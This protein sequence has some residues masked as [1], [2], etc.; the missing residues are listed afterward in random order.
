MA[1]KVGRNIEFVDA[2][3]SLLGRFWVLV[4]SLG[5]GLV[6]GWIA[7][8]T[9]IL[10]GYSP[11]SYWVAGLFG[12]LLFAFI[13]FATNRAVL[14]FHQSR[15]LA[16]LR[17]PV[18]AVNP[19]ESSFSNQ[20]IDL[21]SFV[22]PITHRVSGK[23]FTDCELVGPALVW[24]TRC[25][26]DSRATSKPTLL[27]SDVISVEAV[28]EGTMMQ[29]SPNVIVLRECHFVNCSFISTVILMQEDDAAKLGIGPGE[30]TL[31]IR[32]PNIPV[33]AKT[34]DGDSAT[35]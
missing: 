20:R 22:D 35:K 19:L 34:S 6:T 25:N 31:L 4:V 27:G 23:T 7:T 15:R 9:T 24:L 12:T 17:K 28:P 14:A 13:L 16:A 30:N 11:L 2:V 10:D 5:G 3:I 26:I 33:P 29:T 18:D 1:E 21:H 8:V 32:D